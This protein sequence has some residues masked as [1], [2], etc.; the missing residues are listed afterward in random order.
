M[1]FKFSKQKP[2]LLILAFLTATAADAVAQ[3]KKLPTAEEVIARYV[4]VT[5][6]IEKYKSIKTLYQSGTMS[7]PAVGINGT[8]ELRVES[9][10][11][12]LINA[13]MGA[14]GSET[15]GSDGETVW[16]ES[17]IGTR[18]L[19]GKE[20]DQVLME[21]DFRRFYD[22]AKVYKSLKVVGTEDVDGDECYK[23]EVVK[24][25]GDSQFEFYSAKTGLQVKSESNV[26]SPMG[27]INIES[28]IVEYQDVD[29]IKFPKKVNQKFVQ[30]GMVMEIDFDKVEFNQEF[31]AGTFDLP[32][33]IKK[34]VE[35]K[36]AKAAE[37]DK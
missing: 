17:T 15:S 24:Q 11:K 35:R 3:E 29:G 2:M 23:L 30:Q 28:T 9:P 12:L 34:M 32:E 6:G 20:R 36:K 14:A 16:S 8:M 31:E 7:I 19:S 26:Q 4:E 22:P 37:K 25:S 5:G 13:D 18:I 33:E 10:N 27:A 1:R 21:A